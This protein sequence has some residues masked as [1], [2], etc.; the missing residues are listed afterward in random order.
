[1][2]FFLIVHHGRLIRIF[3]AAYFL[4]IHHNPKQRASLCLVN[5]LLIPKNDISKKNIFHLGGGYD[6]KIRKCEELRLN[7]CQTIENASNHSCLCL[8]YFLVGKGLDPLS[9]QVYAVL[10]IRLHLSP[11]FHLVYFGIFFQ[12]FLRKHLQHCPRF[13]H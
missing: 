7:Q 10:L 2:L 1:M 12:Q 13:S 4:H 9:W 5:D 6:I 3:V 11:N 8:G